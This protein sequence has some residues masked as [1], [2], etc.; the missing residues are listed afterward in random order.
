MHRAGQKIRAWREARNPPLTAEEFG[1]LY[2]DPAPWPSRSVYGWE[3]QGKI[4][5]AAVQ[6]RLAEL[7]ICSPADWL[8]PAETEPAPPQSTP[9]MK[10]TARMSGSDTHPFFDL[11][12]HG[13]VRVATC[14]PALRPAD[15]AFNAQGIVAQAQRADARNVD[16]LLFPERARQ[17]RESRRPAK[18]E[19]CTMCGDFCAN[20]K[21]MELFRT[22]TGPDKRLEECRP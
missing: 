9:L 17:I 15:V 5:R 8:E 3:A 20:R 4:A 14:T 19:T 13:F 22:C 10:G 16:L 12:S 21:G 2:G 18:E 6:K 11:H 1:A 7:G